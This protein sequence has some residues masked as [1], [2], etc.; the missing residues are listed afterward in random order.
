MPT[1]LPSVIQ[2]YLDAATAPNYDALVAC[3]THDAIVVDDGRA[4]RGHAQIRAW[5][6]SLAAAFDYTVEVIEV[7]SSGPSSYVVTARVAG[8][9]P[10]SPVDLRYQF[11][12]VDGLISRLEIAP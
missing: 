11:T 3:F 5:R 9:F 10:G 2:S 4:Y 12:V 7:V 6:E 8:A 1:R